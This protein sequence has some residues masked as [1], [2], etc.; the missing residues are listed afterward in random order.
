MEEICFSTLINYVQF[1]LNISSNVSCY[2]HV[3]IKLRIITELLKF[4]TKNKKVAN[5]S[6]AY[7]FISNILI[8]NILVYILLK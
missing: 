5:A 4:Y 8:D 2:K 7:F 3:N 1:Q 6:Y